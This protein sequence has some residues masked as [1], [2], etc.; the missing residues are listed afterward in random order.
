MT[1]VFE[2]PANGHTEEVGSGASFGVFFLGMIYLIYK[3]LWAHVFIW[4]LVVV[5][6]SLVAGAPILVFTLPAVSIGYAIGIQEILANKY[7]EKGWR[8]PSATA[9][10]KSPLGIAKN[11]GQPQPIPPRVLGQPDSVFNPSSV[12]LEPASGG[13]TT[14]I[15]PFCAEEIK[16]AAIKC[17]H[18]QSD[19]AAAT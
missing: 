11:I 4:F 8:D 9:P 2:N 18:C 7:L 6:P 5:L 14:K 17:K 1:R 16:A 19:L 3:G 12:K 15:C 13:Q 10:S